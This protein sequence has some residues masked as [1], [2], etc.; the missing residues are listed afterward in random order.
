M[1]IPSVVVTV[2][3]ALV[4]AGQVITSFQPLADRLKSR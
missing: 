3:K 1:V 4:V 2:A